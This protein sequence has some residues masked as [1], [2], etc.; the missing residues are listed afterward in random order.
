MRDGDKLEL[1]EWE[2]ITGIDRWVSKDYAKSESPVICISVG[3]LISETDTCIWLVGT[4]HQSNDSL[5]NNVTIIMK[6]VIIHRTL[7]RRGKTV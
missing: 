7:L 4:K 2:D 1:I 5:V 3:W 6:S